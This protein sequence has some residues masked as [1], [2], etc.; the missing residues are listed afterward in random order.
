MHTDVC[1]RVFVRVMESERDEGEKDMQVCGGEGA[2][3]K[4]ELLEVDVE[5]GHGPTTSRTHPTTS[6]THPATR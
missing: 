5:G 1:A 2:G 6:R 3:C 4:V